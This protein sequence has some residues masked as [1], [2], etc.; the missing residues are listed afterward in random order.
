MAYH[1]AAHVVAELATAGSTPD[2]VSLAVDPTQDM[3]GLTHNGSFLLAGQFGPYVLASLPIDDVNFPDGE[4]REQFERLVRHQIHVYAVICAAG[5]AAQELAERL[6]DDDTHTDTC[7]HQTPHRD[8]RH[9]E[10]LVEKVS[11]KDNVMGFISWVYDK[12]ARL[13]EANWEA[14]EAL[15][16]A[17]EERR[18]L[19][20]HDLDEILSPALRKSEMQ[21]AA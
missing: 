10:T 6:N 15:A 14:I 21:R 3:I 2:G 20:R 16:A 12:A 1:Q 9:L 8:Q 4:S 5:D 11:N 19:N 18:E 13:V 17:L 7:P